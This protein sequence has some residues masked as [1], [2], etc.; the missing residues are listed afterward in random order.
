MA[1]GDVLRCPSCGGAPEAVLDRKGIVTTLARCG[2]CRLLYRQ[3]VDAP[4]ASVEFYQEAYSQGYTTDV[5][6]PATLERLKAQGFRG[7]ERD[8]TR[9]FALIEALGIPQGARV[10]EFGCSWGYGAWQLHKAG[11]EVQ[12]FEVSAPRCRYAVDQ[13]QVQAVHRPED[14]RGP[15]DLIFSSHV[16]EHVDRLGPCLRDLWEKLAPGGKMLHVTPNGS[17][18]YRKLAP[19]NWHLLWGGRHPQLLDEEFCSTHFAGKAFFL[20]STPYDLESIKSWSAAA[21]Q[22]QEPGVFRM[23]GEELLIAAIKE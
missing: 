9:F 18:R 20:D 8:Y 17:L 5:P 1:G 4:E 23:E 11:Y 12:A 7:T 14:I 21:H 3:P 19:S 16:L 15:F 6:D 2:G 22:P 10:L 13:L